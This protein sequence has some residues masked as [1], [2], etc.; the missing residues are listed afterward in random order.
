MNRVAFRVWL[1]V[2]MMTIG[3]LTT[4]WVRSG[5]SFEVHPLRESLDKLPLDL[6]GYQG[7]EVSVDDRVAEILHADSSINRLYKRADGRS[8]TLFMSAW[9]RPESIADV[10]PHRPEICYANAGWKLLERKV[11]EASTPQGT[12]PLQVLLFEKGAERCVVAYWYQI[13][14]SVFSTKSEAR[15]IHRSLWGKSQWPA[16]VKVMLQTPSQGIDAARP[17]IEQFVSTVFEWSADL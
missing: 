13:G 14:K 2:G 7:A 17:Q 1:V 8:L 16:T 3:W 10:A 12:L 11:V 4:A 6:N 9:F 5:Y 15:R